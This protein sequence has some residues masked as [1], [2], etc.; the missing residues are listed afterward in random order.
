M[1]K[2][3]F[4]LSLISTYYLATTNVDAKDSES[5][6]KAFHH[7]F[8]NAKNVHSI[9]KANGITEYD[10]MKNGQYV[11]AFIDNSGKIIETDYETAFSELPQRAKT[12]IHNSYANSVIYDVTKVVYESNYFYKVRMEAGGLSYYMAITPEGEVTIGF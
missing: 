10:F 6:E 7:A 1:K 12:L 8:H 4:I 11:A 2:I 3:I 9:E 5:K